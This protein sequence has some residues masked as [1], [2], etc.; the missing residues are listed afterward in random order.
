MFGKKF[1]CP[2]YSEYKMFL[3]KLFYF[4]VNVLVNKYLL[5]SGTKSKIKL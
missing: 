5:F 4:K 3:Y 1:M 2:K